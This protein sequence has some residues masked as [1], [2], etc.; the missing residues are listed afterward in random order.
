MFSSMN[1]V[2]RKKYD[3]RLS[4]NASV[5]PLKNRNTHEMLELS[6]RAAKRRLLDKR[7]VSRLSETSEVRGYNSI[8]KL[9]RIKVRNSRCFDRQSRAW[10]IHRTLTKLIE[11]NEAVRIDCDDF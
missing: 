8:A 4:T 9:P 10:I 6:Y 2:T 3:L 7:Y 1:R 5:R 11:G